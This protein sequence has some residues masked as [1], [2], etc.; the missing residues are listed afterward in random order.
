MLLFLLLFFFAPNKF[1]FLSFASKTKVFKG[2]VVIM[3]GQRSGESVSRAMV[4]SWRALSRTGSSYFFCFFCFFKAV[5]NTRKSDGKGIFLGEGG[6]EV[7]CR[8]LRGR[9]R[10]RN[11]V[12]LWMGRGSGG[13]SSIFYRGWKGKEP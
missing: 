9:W 12:V 3:L 1:F 4:V 2:C 6:G 10:G 13:G 11:V 7:V 8:D 5:E